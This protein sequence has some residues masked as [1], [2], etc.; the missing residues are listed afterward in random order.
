MKTLKLS[1]C[2]LLMMAAV[3]CKK[4]GNDVSA[5]SSGGVSV[6][7][8]ADMAATSLAINS[9]GAV[10]AAGDVYASAQVSVTLHVP[11][12]TTKSDSVSRQN[13]TGSTTYNYKAKYSY[14][15]NCT[16]NIPDNIISSYSYSGSYSG[17]RIST[18]SSGSSSLTATH[19]AVAD[20]AAVLNGEYTSAGSFQSK[21]DTASHGSNNVDIKLQNLTIVK[22]PKHFSSGTATFSITGSTPK[23][24]SFS[25][26]GT[27]V[28]NSDNTATM[29][30]NGTVY[31]VDL[32]TGEKT[33]H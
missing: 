12:G 25:F 21:V 22:K 2:V 6:D 10:S 20:T 13:T 14:T 31:T 32:T 9:N 11:C 7:D 27:L 16:N 26:T 29:T 8:A 17:P 19:L 3:A 18:S 15:V 23:K 33:K 4:N 1:A 28:F 5:S 30:I 24:G